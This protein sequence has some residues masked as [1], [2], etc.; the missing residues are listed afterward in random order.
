MAKKVDEASKAFAAVKN[1]IVTRSV[2]PAG[3]SD[4]AFPSGAPVLDVTDLD[5]VEQLLSEAKGLYARL[6]R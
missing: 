2:S 6:S 1:T 5:K 4:L 3:G